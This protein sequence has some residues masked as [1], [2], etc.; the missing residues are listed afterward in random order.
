MHFAVGRAGGADLFYWKRSL[1]I[2]MRWRVDTS[3]WPFL[4][5][6]LHWFPIQIWGRDG[7]EMRCEIREFYEA[8]I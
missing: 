1:K 8:P 5:L 4:D 2:E 6:L 7:Q 3:Y